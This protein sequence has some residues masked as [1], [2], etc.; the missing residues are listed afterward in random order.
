M[1]KVSV[2]EIVQAPGAEFD[3]LKELIKQEIHCAQPGIVR[4]YNEAEQ[5]VTV[6]LAIRSLMNGKNVRPPL[7]SDVPVFFPGGKGAG[8]TFPISQGDECLVVFS[9]C[10]IDAWFQNGGSSS[11]ISVRKHDIS[12]GFAFVGFR[13]KPN[14]IQ[15]LNGTEM[16]SKNVVLDLIYPVGAVYFSTVETNPG[17][18]FGGVWEEMP[19]ML[20]YCWTRV[21]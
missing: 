11:P 13:S 19:E 15:N 8:F 7:L 16:L 9:D 6:E 10:C 1:S 3:R 2:D 14:R 5:T 18:L 4:S 21:S 17:T 20:M 12:D